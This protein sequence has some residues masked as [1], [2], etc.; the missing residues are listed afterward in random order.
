MYLYV[1]RIL[2]HV[3]SRTSADDSL[4]PGRKL[5]ELTVELNSLLNS[6]DIRFFENNM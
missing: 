2:F 1:N 5:A 4:F 6:E 3:A